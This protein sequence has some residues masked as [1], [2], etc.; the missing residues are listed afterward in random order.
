[1]NALG[2]ALARYADAPGPLRWAAA[3]TAGAVALVAASVSTGRP[4]L[5]LAAVGCAAVAVALAAPAASR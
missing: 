3:L 1:V 2:R 4:A 5:S